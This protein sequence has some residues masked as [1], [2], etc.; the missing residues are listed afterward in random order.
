[1]SSLKKLIRRPRDRASASVSEDSGVTAG[2]EPAR[3][4]G[5]HP[6]TETPQSSKAQSSSREVDSLKNIHV[7]EPPPCFHATDLVVHGASNPRLLNSDQKLIEASRELLYALKVYTSSGK[8]RN[9]EVLLL[10]D[11]PY[12]ATLDNVRDPEL[13]SSLIDEFLAQNQDKKSSVSIRFGSVISKVYPLLSLVL[14]IGSTVAEGATFVPVKGT[15]NGLSLLLAIADQEHTKTTDFLKQLDRLGFQALR[16]AELKKA[17]VEMNDILL[18]KATDLMTAILKFFRGALIYLKHDFFYNVYKGVLLGPK[19]YTDAKGDLNDAIKEY[20]QA[21]LL[22]VTLSQIRPEISEPQLDLGPTTADLIN[23]LQSSHWDVEAEFSRHCDS[24][25]DGTLTWVFDMPEFRDWRLAGRDESVSSSLWLSGLPGV[26]KSTTAAYIVQALKA[27]H[28][29]ATVLY[30]FCNAG[31]AKLDNLHQLVRTLAAQLV[32]DVPEA[33][34]H[35]QDLKEKDFDVTKPDAI[36]LYQ[37]LFRDPL[38]GT[39]KDTFVILDGLDECSPGDEDGMEKLLTSLSSL[40]LKLLVTSRITCEIS[41]GLSLGTRRDIGYEDSRADLQLYIAHCL[42]RSKTLQKGFEKLDLNASEFLTEKSQGNF[43][44]VKL[45]LDTLKRKT[46]ARDF[47]QVIETLPRDL[48]GVYKQVLQRLE[49][50]DRLTLALTVFRCVLCSMRP[51]TLAE[52]EIAV[53]LILEDSV[54][55]I[56][57][58]IENDCGMILKK[59]PTWPAT[60]YIGHETFRSFI[61]SR[62]SSADNCVE[63]AASHAQVLR[64][65][66]G[67]LLEPKSEQ[68][69]TLRD[70]AVKYWLDHLSEV[71][72]SGDDV[73]YE[74]RRQILQDLYRL[75]DSKMVVEAWLRDYVFD[76][77]EKYQ[78]DTLVASFHNLIVEFLRSEWQKLEQD[79]SFSGSERIWVESVLKPGDFT[80]ELCSTFRHVWLSTNWRELDTA[81]WV[82]R[83]ASALDYAMDHV[84]LSPQL[85]KEKG[86]KS[87]Y[88][89]NGCPRP[90]IDSIKKAALEGGI[91]QDNAVH[92]GNY[93]IA[94]A[95][96]DSE[97]CVSQF[98]EALDECS[99]CWHLYEGLAAYY[100]KHDEIAKALENLERAVKA[101]TKK[102]PSGMFE[103]S[104]LRS[105]MKRDADDLEG[106]VEA[107]KDGLQRAS[108]DNAPQYWDAMAAIFE[109]RGDGNRMVA[110]YEEAAKCH[111][112][113]GTVYWEKLAETYGRGGARQQEWQAYRTAISK[114]PENTA[115]YGERIRKIAHE[116]RS[117]CVWP[118]I[119]VI[120]NQGAI[121]DPDHAAEYYKELGEAF[122]CQRLWKE[123]LEQFEKYTEKTDN[124][125]IYEDIGAAYLGLGDT[126]RSLSAYEVAFSQEQLVSRALSIGYVHVIKGDF[127]KAIRL[128]K[129]AIT[130]I[131]SK[132]YQEAAPFSLGQVDDARQQRIFDLHVQLALC[133]EATNRQGDMLQQLEVAVGAL[134]PIILETDKD[135]DREMVYRHT[136][137]SLF[138][139]G[140]VEEKL[141]RIGDS[142]ESLER[143]V[144]LFEKT[145][146]ESDDDIQQSEAD[147]ARAALGRVAMDADGKRT[148]SIPDMK[149]TVGSMRLQRRLAL[150]YTTDWYCVQSWEPPRHRGAREWNQVS[151]VN[152]FV[153]TA[154]QRTFV[155][156]WGFGHT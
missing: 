9:E 61:T 142:K 119:T 90:S 51:M 63:A 147:E 80:K 36:F 57:D 79:G 146:M 103:L 117:L 42:S 137:R 40:S 100:L 49:S 93:A 135:K 105:K 81:E 118:P 31:D 52:V 39:K 54:F 6:G 154:G 65:C 107:F 138:R 68:F 17:G 72:K 15:V 59:T 44:W 22:Q 47:Q 144:F 116:L 19:A 127:A 82:V 7:A 8:G 29:D 99:D 26:G 112:K 122:M 27:Q 30:F 92:V 108:E 50:R 114:D 77:R 55:D 110:I 21:L 18:E 45:V 124:K 139:I 75:C 37:K 41:S 96:I 13:L 4:D 153:I 156:P 85:I 14:G 64:G 33:R 125:W 128:F 66:I 134:K 143:A 78:L 53:G 70:Y 87:R 91:D 111:P 38:Q 133:Y 1:M 88:V 24:R 2:L 130:R 10:D 115:R 145:S 148:G 123:A 74:G 155:F 35:M 32:S 109:S 60:I 69:G 97:Q 98:E 46:S 11:D 106:A 28:P 48:E 71:F 83:A 152:K 67:C 129:A 84:A 136:A 5:S 150:P 16:V 3:Q 34:Y 113:A 62:D 131:S 104:K 102:H 89:T 12:N 23:W 149:E 151:F 120:L 101:D 94:L 126:E 132:D 73:S 141:D 76:S 140:L 43:L 58:F 121:E 25:V 95:L 86:W 56:E 20:D